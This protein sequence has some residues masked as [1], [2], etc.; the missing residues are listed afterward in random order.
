[1]DLTSRWPSER[2]VQRAQASR[3][4]LIERIA[5]AIRDD[6]TTEPL[7]GLQ[8]RRASSPTE[9]YHYPESL[10]DMQRSCQGAWGRIMRYIA[11]TSTRC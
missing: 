9:P 10:F 11:A 6:E 4:E 1:M 7:E 3:D 2:E 8:L 5:W